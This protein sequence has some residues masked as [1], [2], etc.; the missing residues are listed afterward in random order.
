MRK[1]EKVIRD[2]SGERSTYKER[3]RLRKGPK[4]RKTRAESEKERD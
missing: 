4:H 2:R 1:R 3:E